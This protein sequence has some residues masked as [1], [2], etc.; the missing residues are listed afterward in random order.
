MIVQL[1]YR[2]GRLT[3]ASRRPRT[4]RGREMRDKKL[5]PR[6]TLPDNFTTLEELWGFWDTH[7]SADYE[8]VMEA[9]E[10]EID[11]SSSKMHS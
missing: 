6:D 11:L 4:A 7:S 1:E 2:N 9:V 8:D 3:C 5:P 10:I